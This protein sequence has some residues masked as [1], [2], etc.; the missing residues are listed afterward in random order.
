VK[1]KS[2]R[3]RQPNER[4]AVETAGSSRRGGKKKKAFSKSVGEKVLGGVDLIRA[5]QG[6]R[7]IHQRNT[8]VIEKKSRETE[9]GH[10]G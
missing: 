6:F 2:I 8:T 5:F 4:R 9:G 1:T 10:R 3:G 7:V